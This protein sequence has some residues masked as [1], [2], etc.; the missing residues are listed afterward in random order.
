MKIAHV[1]PTYWPAVRYG[2]PIFSVHGLCKSLV[3]NG[4]EVDVYTTNVDGD[5]VLEVPVGT[6]VDVD[7]V[8]VRYFPTSAGRRIYRSPAMAA[9]LEARIQEYDV[10]HTH[11]IFLWPVLAASRIAAR[12][13]VPYISTRAACWCAN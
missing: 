13:S 10:V 7:G 2:G 12:H 11:S 5:G 6:P 1:V 9:E 4:I 3:A 8:K